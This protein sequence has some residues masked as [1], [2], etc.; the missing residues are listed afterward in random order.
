M[1]VKDLGG[2]G[3]WGCGGLSRGEGGGRVLLRRRAVILC[4]GI[5]WGAFEGKGIGRCRRWRAICAKGG[6][7]SL[8]YDVGYT[9]LSMTR[10][11]CMRWH[12]KLVFGRRN[13]SSEGAR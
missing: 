7:D 8:V 2:W 11:G 1:A 6:M 9:Y 13:F 10:G 5:D 3:G 12:Q 4:W